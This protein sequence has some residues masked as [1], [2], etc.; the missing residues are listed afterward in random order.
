MLNMIWKIRTLLNQALQGFELVTPISSALMHES[1]SSSLSL[2][3]KNLEMNTSPLNLIAAHC[4]TPAS[5]GI[6]G[7]LVG[8]LEISGSG[9]LQLTFKVIQSSVF[10]R[11]LRFL[12]DIYMLWS[13]LLTDS[14]HTPQMQMLGFF[15]CSRGF[16]ELLPVKTCFGFG[17]KLGKASCRV[18]FVEV[19]KYNSAITAQP[20]VLQQSCKPTENS[21]HLVV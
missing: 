18:A 6:S 5:C 21:T 11:G 10:P 7:C 8:L 2:P 9:F 3:S 12:N 16:P 4:D 1:F 17:S 15:P 20:S 13:S 19:V 14:F